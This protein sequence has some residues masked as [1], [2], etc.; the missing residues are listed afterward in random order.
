MVLRPQAP[1]ILVAIDLISSKMNLKTDNPPPN[2]LDFW[3]IR[4]T[5]FDFKLDVCFV[6]IPT[7]DS[8]S[9]GIFVFGS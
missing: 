4:F 5:K 2:T 6:P 7:P 9:P 1:K 3:L 8:N